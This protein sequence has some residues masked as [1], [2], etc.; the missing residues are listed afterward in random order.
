MNRHTL[1]SAVVLTAA[2]LVATVGCAPVTSTPGDGATVLTVDDVRPRSLP[3]WEALATADQDRR[4]D[5]LK[6]GVTA[7]RA[8]W[9]S[10]AVTDDEDFNTHARQISSAFGRVETALFRGNEGL[11]YHQMGVV[12]ELIIVLNRNW[13]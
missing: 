5:T 8:V 6:R 12:N 10:I 11:A 1:L 9:E 2:T 7:C 3:C 13:G 4:T